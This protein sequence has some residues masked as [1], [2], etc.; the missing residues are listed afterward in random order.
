MLPVNLFIV[1]AAKS[2]TTSLWKYLGQHPE[3][4]T[5]LDEL[6]KEPAF[7]SA[8]GETLGLR[9]YQVLFKDSVNER[10][11]CDASTAYLTSPESAERIHQYNPLA[12][13]IAIVRNPID[14]AYSLYNWMV[15]DGYEWAPTFEMAL[16]LESVRAKN[17]NRRFFMPEYFWNYMY[18]QSGF[19][20][21]QLNRYRRL[22]G[23]NL[24]VVTFEDMI[25]APSN[26]TESVCN[27]LRIKHNPV[28]LPKENRSRRARFAPLTFAAR[29]WIDIR[30]R[31]I[32]QTTKASR[33]RL[34][35]LTLSSKS[36]QP[37][38]N[39]LRLQL[40]RRFESE[41]DRLFNAY[42]IQYQSE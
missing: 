15:G 1:G 3:V 20:V 16:Q 11:R 30:S 23:D 33:D 26:A 40:H 12:K 4:Y 29:K 22:F 24:M 10:Y 25:S 39:D 42:G 14:R 36:P 13:V 32:Q 8:H 19:Y 34:I 31:G 6:H 41:L 27:F 28:P 18:V 2:G 21:E 17:G 7:F 35:G 9:N 5:T 37:L 38:S